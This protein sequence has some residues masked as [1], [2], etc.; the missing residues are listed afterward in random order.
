[1]SGRAVGPGRRPAMAGR[2]PRGAERA[3]RAGSS[4]APPVRAGTRRDAGERSRCGHPADEGWGEPVWPV[5]MAI[6]IAFRFYDRRLLEARTWGVS[7]NGSCWRSPV[8]S[9]RAGTWAGWAPGGV[10]GGVTLIR[11]I[12]VEACVA[13]PYRGRGSAG[14]PGTARPAFAKVSL[15]RTSSLLGECASGIAASRRPGDCSLVEPGR[16]EL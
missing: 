13:T 7:R 9:R 12:L 4:P 14:N 2:S 1:M 10:D 3:A 5:T 6:T 11:E 15:R 8:G 16:I